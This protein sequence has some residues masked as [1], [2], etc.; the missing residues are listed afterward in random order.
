ME[1][2]NKNKRPAPEEELVAATKRETKRAKLSIV[3]DSSS[4]DPE[5]SS[6]SSGSSSD[7]DD[8][9]KKKK[10]TH[11]LPE[12]LSEEHVCLVNLIVG[13]LEDVMKTPPHVLLDERRD[14]ALKMIADELDAVLPM[15]SYDA[16]RFLARLR[17]EMDV[18]DC[19]SADGRARILIRI[20]GDVERRVRRY[21]ETTT[22][23]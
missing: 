14:N 1:E 23:Q 15:Q 8:D 2:E 11:K 5:E 20:R 16:Y 3:S 21:V 12:P 19:L 4:Y 18:F 7:S 17:D 10:K 13:E 22:I 9:R 6:G